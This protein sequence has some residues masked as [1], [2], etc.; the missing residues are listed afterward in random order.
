MDSTENVAVSAAMTPEQAPRDADIDDIPP[1]A[2]S[3]PANLHD[4]GT[5][6]TVESAAPPTSNDSNGE[7]I[8]GFFALLASSNVQMAADAAVELSRRIT[9]PGA[10]NDSVLKA[11]LEKGGMKPFSTRQANLNLLKKWVDETPQRRP[12]FLLNKSQLIAAY[13]AKFG[14]SSSS[15]QKESKEE[16]IQRLALRHFQAPNGRTNSSQ[17]A[18]TH[19]AAEESLRNSLLTKIVE[20]S[21]MPRLNAKGKEFCKSGHQLERPFG[22]KLLKHSKEGITKF[23]VEELFR[24]GLVGKSE[25]MYAKASTDFIG[26][27]TV[28]GVQTLV[29]VECKGRLTPGT[30][31]AEREHAEDLSRRG[32]AETDFARST[33]ELYTVIEASSSD[34][35]KYVDSTHEAVQ[36]LHTAYVY[37]FEYVLLLVGDSA[38]NIIRGE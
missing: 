35:H 8:E 33:P 14:G 15:L 9:T 16:L 19:S 30:S 26:V 28:D 10:L 27:A 6:P 31:Q 25:A 3:P 1:P 38:G 20:A 13:V 29:A 24:V 12:Y 17:S 34:Y 7:D 36:L 2:F 4:D 5:Q 32:R 37:S 11:Y 22:E 23:K 18:N 21:F